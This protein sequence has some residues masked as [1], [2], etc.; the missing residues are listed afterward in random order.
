M[1]GI[2]ASS[3]ASF[4]GLIM[5]P[6]PSFSPTK[7]KPPLKISIFNHLF[8][9]SGISIPELLTDSPMS[10]KENCKQI[11][12]SNEFG[13]DFNNQLLVGHLQAAFPKTKIEIKEVSLSNYKQVIGECVEITKNSIW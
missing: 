2:I 5:R 12:T 7:T 8:V 11:A 3:L 4:R 10:S 1:P 13:R 9:L 6:S